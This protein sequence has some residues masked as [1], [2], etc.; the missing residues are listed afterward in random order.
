MGMIGAYTGTKTNEL[1][2][3]LSIFLGTLLVK[4][5]I[6]IKNEHNAWA[7]LATS[8]LQFGK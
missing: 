2:K 3:R 7:N 1:A 5:A 6:D 4:D 8:N